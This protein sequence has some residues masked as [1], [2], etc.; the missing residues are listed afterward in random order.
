[1]SAPDKLFQ[2]A[3]AALNS[4]N[5]FEAERLFT[6]FLKRQPKHVGA[7]NLLTVVLMGLERFAEAEPL[8]SKAVSLNSGSEVSF[9]N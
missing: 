3:L 7:L 5:L 9:Y 4:R 1:M 2:D 8:I 6:K